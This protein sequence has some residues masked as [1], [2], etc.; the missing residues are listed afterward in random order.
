MEGREGTGDVEVGLFAPVEFPACSISLSVGS[1]QNLGSRSDWLQR[2]R[3]T[4]IALR[5]AL[6][7][8]GP[9]RRARELQQSS[10]DSIQS[11]VSVYSASLPVIEFT[12]S[13]LLI[14]TMRK[15]RLQMPL[16]SRWRH[17]REA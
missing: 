3:V 16:F 8:I 11:R 10:I 1:V 4:C 6:S 17:Y 12:A 9:Y 15:I 5:L 7:R 13:V 14:L 2:R